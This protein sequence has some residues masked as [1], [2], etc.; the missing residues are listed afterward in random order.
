MHPTNQT[1]A[2]Q[3]TSLASQMLAN[4]AS[5][6]EAVSS[7]TRSLS[8]ADL[9]PILRSAS[10]RL[11]TRDFMR[12]VSDACGA[13]MPAEDVDR[14]KREFPRLLVAALCSA[15]VKT[16][17]EL[18]DSARESQCSTKLA[19]SIDAAR[20]IGAELLSSHYYFSYDFLAKKNIR[21]SF[22]DFHSAPCKL[23]STK[24]YLD[25]S[26]TIECSTG[27]ELSE[28]YHA[29]QSARFF[30]ELQRDFDSMDRRFSS[31]RM[32]AAKRASYLNSAV[33][34]LGP[35]LEKL[36]VCLQ[37]GAPDISKPGDPVPTLR[38]SAK[39]SGSFSSLVK[40]AT[41]AC[42]V[43]LG[44]PDKTIKALEQ[45]VEPDSTPSV[46]LVLEKG[47]LLRYIASGGTDLSVRVL[48]S[49]EKM[50]RSMLEEVGEFAKAGVLFESFFGRPVEVELCHANLH[51][52]VLR[53]TLLPKR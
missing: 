47:P 10:Q 41:G 11:S 13:A 35:H 31:S 12:A 40:E 4:A 15:Q 48:R 32:T 6:E 18:L 1:H 46:S 9:P 22:E 42:Q 51:L 16:A 20:A 39:I 17:L 30:L 38:Q 7:L 23:F 45:V 34:A 52:H 29:L 53:L 37:A 3:F 5:Y 21:V 24:L 28:L 43:R 33:E 27:E 26:N 2:A 44:P 49:T 19:Q 36:G 8:Q 25:E 14:L 50:P